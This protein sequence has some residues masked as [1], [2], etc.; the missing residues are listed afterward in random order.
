MTQPSDNTM[1]SYQYIELDNWITVQIT[2]VTSTELNLCNW[3]LAFINVRSLK[4]NEDL[5]F[6]YLPQMEMWQWRC[7]LETTLMTT[8]LEIEVVT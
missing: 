6:G 5:L 2:G 3:K 1:P 4:P 8:G 7:G